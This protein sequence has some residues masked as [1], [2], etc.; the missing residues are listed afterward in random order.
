MELLELFTPDDKSSFDLTIFLLNANLLRL[1][2]TSSNKVNVGGM[3][4]KLDS[5]ITLDLVQTKYTA[6]CESSDESRSCRIESMQNGFI[7]GCLNLIWV[8]VFWV[9]YIPIVSLLV[10]SGELPHVTVLCISSRFRLFIR[11]PPF[12]HNED[13]LHS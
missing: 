5:E 2:F 3:L 13:C 7:G 9:F 11:K 8:L 1:I 6:V 10:K 12:Q 4:R